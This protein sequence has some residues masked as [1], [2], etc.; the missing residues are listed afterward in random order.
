MNIANRL[1]ARE[2]SILY[3]SVVIIMMALA[4]NFAIEPLYKEWDSIDKET[5]LI[6]V[7]LQKAISA[8]KK[9]EEIDK[10]YN[11]YAAKL[12]PRGSDEQEVTFILNELE[13]LAR[14]SS[15]KIV[16]MRPKPSKDK[17]YYKRFTVDIETESD[18]R[19]LM[20][21][22]YKVR[23]SPQLLKIDKLQLN[24]KSG[25]DGLVIKASMVISKITF[26]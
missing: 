15:L 19:S 14:T 26:K 2:K 10:E 22:I 4:Y 8:V 21:F 12:K 24:T 1:S 20:M 17:D 13:T 16:N 25:E 9:K 23:N 6:R 18:M 11:V 5:R 7:K 3:A